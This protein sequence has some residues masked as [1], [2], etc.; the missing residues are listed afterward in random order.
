M[1]ALVSWAP[2]LYAQ[3]VCGPLEVCTTISAL[4]P[5]LDSEDAALAIAAGPSA[6][7]LAR[8]NSVEL[9]SSAGQLQARASTQDFFR[10]VRAQGANDL[11]HPDAI[12]EP[13][14]A[15]F[16]LVMSDAV[17]DFRCAPGSCKFVYLIAVSKS[18]TPATLDSASWHFYSW[19]RTVD[20]MPAG[21]TVTDHYGY[22]DRLATAGGIIMISSEMN[23]LLDDLGRPQKTRFFRAA[24]MISGNLP[25]AWL[26][27]RDVFGQAARNFDTIDQFFYIGSPDSLYGFTRVTSALGTA[28]KLQS[29]LIVN[30]PAPPAAPQ[31]GG[32][33]I[34][35]VSRPIPQHRNGH[36]WLARPVA[37]GSVSAIQWLQVDVRSWPTLRIVQQGLLETPGKFL[38]QPELTVDAAGNMIMLFHRSDASEYPSVWYT[39]RLVADPPGIL[40]QPR[41][42]KTGEAPYVPPSS[43]ETVRFLRNS[44]VSLDFEQM[45]AWVLGMYT[46][47]AGR[48]ATWL[49]R[50][51]LQAIPTPPPIVDAVRDTASGRPGGAAGS[52]ISLYGAGFSATAM[53]WSASIRPGDRVLPTRL[54]G[55][56]VRVAG[57]LTPLHYAGPAQINALL[58]PGAPQGAGIGIEVQ[59][60]NGA[61][62]STLTIQEVLPSLFAIRIMGRDYAAL[63]RP[64]RSGEVLELYAS[65]LGPTDPP[66]PSGEILTSAF[67]LRD[68]SRM[69]VM[70]GGRSVDV[71]FGGLIAPGLYQVN[72]RLPVLLT[73]DHAITLSLDGRDS[74]PG[75]FIPIT[76]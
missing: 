62:R 46:D 51:A 57:Q 58:P 10:S 23:Q 54:N 5:N 68:A 41:L 35:T 61:A 39:G 27:Y 31:R 64:A 26:D 34:R 29:S 8:K 47:A 43:G 17:I 6:I 74:Q 33:P 1:L 48:Q 56:E 16:F 65:G 45:S 24:E 36:V 66:Y 32:K 55:I 44:G 3:G 70:V 22:Q 52:F 28:E 53:D 14:T 13:T 2:A 40:R 63:S 67:P 75:V 7:V 76:P 12:F 4:L 19:D 9:R 25:A 42:I 37:S 30:A 18:S 59:S 20:R 50:I 72:I 11:T 38:Y 15:R 21:T 49:A 73:G 60:P 69:R 71:L